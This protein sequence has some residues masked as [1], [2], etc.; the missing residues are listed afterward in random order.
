[1]T[2]WICAEC[3]QKNVALGR[4]CAHCGSP[5]NAA[6][7]D[8]KADAFVPPWERP[9]W[10]ASRPED[11]CDAGGCTKTVRE[12]I[13]ECL[14]ITSRPGTLFTRPSARDHDQEAELEARRMRLMSQAASLR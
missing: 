8:A 13:D 1:M 7:N 14:A 5:R 6:L 12:H 11:Q 2:T 10:K 9:G 3:A 4:F